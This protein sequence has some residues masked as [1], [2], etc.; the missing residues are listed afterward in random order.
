MFEH[1]RKACNSGKLWTIIFAAKPRSTDSTLAAPYI[2]LDV[3]LG[4][5]CMTAPQD[6]ADKVAFVWKV[7]DKLRG[8]FKQHE[9]GSV[10][11]PLLALRRLDAVLVDT[12]QQVLD[13]AKTFQDIGPGQDVLLKKITGQPFYNTSPLTMQSMLADDKNIAA[14][15]RSYIHG[16]SASAY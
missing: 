7:A 8:N 6:F 5:K 15:L 3:R 10:M 9:Y 4:D 14:Q 16:L 2:S 13:K 11:L 1:K 12:K